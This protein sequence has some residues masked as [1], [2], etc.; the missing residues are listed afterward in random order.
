MTPVEQ[1]PYVTTDRRRHSR[2]WKPFE[3]GSMVILVVQEWFFQFSC[4]CTVRTTLTGCK[5]M[6]HSEIIPMPIPEPIYLIYPVA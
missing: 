2:I 3:E 1:N 5:R 6:P 4:L